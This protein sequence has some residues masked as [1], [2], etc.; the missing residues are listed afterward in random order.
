MEPDSRVGVYRLP[1][2]SSPDSFTMEPSETSPVVGDEFAI[3]VKVRNRGGADA[4]IDFSYRKPSLEEKQPEIVVLK[5]ATEARQA[6]V[7]KCR[8]YSGEGAC[9]QPGEKEFVYWVKAAE[10]TKM[11]LLPAQFEYV[12]VFGER[13]ARESN[14]PSIEAMTAKVKVKPLILSEKE[15]VKVGQTYVGRVA[16]KNTSLAGVSDVRLSL[17]VDPGL[18]LEGNDVKE[19][20]FIPAQGTE[21][22]EVRVKADAP[23]AYA[24]G[25]ETV[26]QEVR[27]RFA[28]CEPVTITVEEDNVNPALLAG[29]ALVVVAGLAYGYIN[30]S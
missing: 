7:P 24:L 4:V 15:I 18:T 9:V 3:A 29:L 14:R 26:Y 19:F 8:A 2:F 27:L 28:E 1:D 5:G 12:D 30:R 11:S 21:Y 17:R 25:C 10:A 16:L 23:G 6:L 22:L 13:Q 20:E